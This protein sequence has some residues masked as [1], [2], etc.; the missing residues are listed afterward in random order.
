MGKTGKKNVLKKIFLLGSCCKLSKLTKF[1][2][3]NFNSFSNMCGLH[4]QEKHL[5]RNV[6]KKLFIN[7]KLTFSLIC[8]SMISSFGKI[9]FK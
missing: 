6:L 4:N 3:K 7:R 5:D 9:N 1:Q 2:S 8:A